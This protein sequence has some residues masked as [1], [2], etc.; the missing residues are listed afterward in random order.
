MSVNTEIKLAAVMTLMMENFSNMELAAFN[1][2]IQGFGKLSPN[3]LAF[4]KAVELKI[5]KDNGHAWDLDTT[6]RASNAEVNRRIKAGEF[7]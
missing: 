6:Q 4:H 1:N 7:N 2:A 3:N 5:L